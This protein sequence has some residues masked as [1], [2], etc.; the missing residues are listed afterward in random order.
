MP[1]SIT[2]FECFWRP[3][4]RLFWLY[5][6]LL[7]PAL[8]ALCL[9]R[10]PGWVQFLAAAAVLLHA[11]WVLP[12]QIG[13]S[14]PQAFIGLRHDAQGFSLFSRQNG[15]QPVQLRPDSLALPLCVVLRFRLPD[16][17]FSHGLCIPF[18]ALPFDTHRRLRVRLKFARKRFQE[19]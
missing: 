4:R 17:W 19:Q 14:H 3:S 10:L 6:G 8:V 12:R 5:F 11:I 16:Q 18:D 13:L 1:Q 7:L 15:W 2:P 9:A